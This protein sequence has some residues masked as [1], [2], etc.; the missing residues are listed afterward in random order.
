MEGEDFCTVEEA[1]RVVQ[2]TPGRVG[3]MLRAG[4]LAGV[5]PE[6]S[7]HPELCGWI[8]KVYPRQSREDRL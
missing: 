7:G 5:S 3:Q 8:G 1:A 2:L 4:E 6:E